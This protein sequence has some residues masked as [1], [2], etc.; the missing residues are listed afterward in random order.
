MTTYTDLAIRAETQ[1]AAPAHTC[2]HESGGPQRPAALP[3]DQGMQIPE[4]LLAKL[5]KERASRQTTLRT[6]AGKRVRVVY[7]GRAGTAAGPDFRDALLE[8]EGLGLV[9][10]DVELHIR[11]RDWDVHGHGGDP[12][13]NGVV[14]HGA[15]DV[16]SGETRLQ[17]GTRAPVV[18]LRALLAGDTG[19]MVGAVGGPS[20]HR[21]PGGR[22]Q[23]GQALDLWQVLAGRGAPRP[24]SSLE[25]EAALD[26]AG[27][28]RFQL[29]ARWLSTC[30]RAQGPG[31][32]LYE[33][34]MEGLGY[35]S[36]R[37]PFLELA[38]RVP[39]QAVRDAAV[40]LPPGE[41]RPAIASWF[42]ACS[43]LDGTEGSLWAHPPRPRS[44][45]PP[46]DRLMGRPMD[47]KEWH[48]FRVRPSN[49]PRRRI[50]GMAVIL[51]RFLE[52]GLAEGLAGVAAGVA[53]GVSRGVASG[54]AQSRNPA[55]LTEALAAAGNSGPA[56]VGQGRAKDLVVNAVLAF[57][58]AWPEARSL[59]AGPETV[60]DIYRRF[61]R[62]SDNELTR[63]MT[64]QL[65]PGEW[66]E[67]VTNA[68]RQQGLLHLS[69]LLKGAY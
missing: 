6:Q 65:L 7:P 3:G 61:P 1:E 2:I 66:R 28:Q 43:G 47:R 23:S 46:M 16:H 34:I 32:T 12:N 39:Y 56:Y 64:E 53:A 22:G 42:H 20:G 67:A 5:W 38:W 55:R 11:Q 57:L 59:G 37:R 69:N 50:M 62:L 29:K 68:R 33:A 9:R 44:V 60:A 63:E 14:V 26:W 10:G 45:G 4:R 31:Q 18:D 48:L 17:C 21:R 58:H 25:A 40:Q 30:I 35:S 54:N 19:D 8:V 36:N 24:G 52:Q 51:D 27:D 49:H 15:L 13:Y 41:R